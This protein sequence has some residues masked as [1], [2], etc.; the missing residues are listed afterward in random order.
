MKIGFATTFDARDISNWSGTPYYMAQTLTN[1]GH[2]VA[3]IGNLSRR[4]PFAFKLIQGWKKLT[5]N[6]RES[7]RFN[8]VAAKHYSKQVATA[9]TH[10]SVD[11][12]LA[13]QI[14]PIAYL[15]SQ[16]PIVLWTDGLYASLL[17]FYP[18]FTQHSATSV[19]QGNLITRE[20]LARTAL[21][22]FS[23]E[24][25]ARTALEIY[26]ISKEKV[27]VVPFGANI[28]CTHT[29][30]DIRAMLRNRPRDRVKLLFLGK[31]WHR[32]GGDIVFQ[33]AKALHAA[34]Q[35][36]ELNFVGCLPPKEISVP[37]YIKCHGFI[38]K[39]TPEGLQKMLQLLRESH[40]LFVPS[41]AEAYGIV[42]CEANAFGLP[43]LTSYVGGIATVV[44]DNVNGKTFSLTATSQ[45]YCDY[46]MQLMQNYSAYENL[47]L[48]SFNEYQDRLNWNAGIRKVTQLIQEIA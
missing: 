23:S 4:L 34:G 15:D 31:H 12:I 38:S 42:F 1:A 5:C 10:A 17:G 37:A 18:G 26:G 14:N 20:C 41:R 36:V 13:P 44:K 35:P 40:F 3:Y 11:V 45:V 16:K 7:P 27:K 8:V 43:C 48:S 46:I 19:Q 32:K 47:A 29:E 22:I 39:R 25:A 6:Q 28:N 9:L 33:V 30:T 2:S 24:W 21:A